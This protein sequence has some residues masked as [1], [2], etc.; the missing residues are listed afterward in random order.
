MTPVLTPILKALTGCPKFSTQIFGFADLEP[1]KVQDLHR[2]SL[3]QLS[4][5]F[6]GEVVENALPTGTV[7]VA[8]TMM[9]LVPNLC[10]DAIT[11]LVG[12][13]NRRPHALV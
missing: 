4:L 7:L 12:V 11:K 9:V 13:K 1:L 8:L 3:K 2:L 5:H 6:A 10:P